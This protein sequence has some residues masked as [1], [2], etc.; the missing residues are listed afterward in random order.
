MSGCLHLPRKYCQSQSDPGQQTHWYRQRE[1]S[2]IHIQI[3]I[4][5]KDINSNC[6]SDSVAVGLKTDLRT[7]IR[8]VR[9]ETKCLAFLPL[10]YLK[11]FCYITMWHLQNHEMSYYRYI[12]GIYKSYWPELNRTLRSSSSPRH[13]PEPVP[14][15]CWRHETS[16]PL[17]LSLIQ[18]ALPEPPPSH[19]LSSTLTLTSLAGWQ[20]D[21]SMRDLSP[22]QD[23]SL[24]H[25]TTGVWSAPRGR[26]VS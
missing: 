21:P 14:R 11:M 19:P 6:R 10:C 3:L 16:G 23:R 17:T 25:T 24:T 1:Y 4:Q 22:C 9:T 8:E 2:S 26:P 12:T 15:K 13:I 18:T 7:R 5:Y 20:H